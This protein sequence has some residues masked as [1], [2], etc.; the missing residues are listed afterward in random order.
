MPLPWWRGAVFY[1]V[2]VR[3][4]ADSNDD[5]VGDLPGITSR[6]DYIRD[7]GVD[8]IW[9]TP[10]YPSPQKDHGYDVA[11]YYSVNP[12]YGTL[13]DFDRLLARAHDLGLKVLVDIVPNH[14]SNQHEW[15][16]AAVASRDS[17][18]RERYHFADGR[19]DG[20]PPNNW[21]SSFGGPAWS[22]EPS[23]DQWYL[24]LFAPEQPDL[25]WW[26]PEVQ[27]E[28]ERILK[29]WLDR[30]A[31][32]FRLD[33]FNAYF[34]DAQY[35]NNPPALGLRGFDRQRHVYDRDQ[36]EMTGL[37]NDLRRLL[38]TYPERMAVGEV[39]G[40][41]P[42]LA[43]RYCGDGADQL[44]LAFNFEFTRQPWLPRAFQQSILRWEAAL[45]SGAWPCQVLSNHDVD[46][47]VTRFGGGP[48]GDARAKVAAAMLLTLRGTPFLYSGE[49]LGLRNTPIPRAEIQDPP[50]KKYWPFY[51]GRDPERSP[52]PWNGGRGAGFTA[53][54][55][56]LRL[57]PD[58]ARR[59]VD[60]QQTDPDSVFNF[61]RQL[62]SLRRAS[63][64]LR[65]GSYHPLLH[66]PVTALAYLRECP[67]QTMLVALNFFGWEANVEVDESLGGKGWRLR[68]SSASGEHARVRGNTLHLAPFEACVLEA[69]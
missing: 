6:L 69:E 17:P 14:T 52:M 2:Y 20:S 65:R 32:G 8:A 34:K 37:L 41:D 11:D 59:N 10:F 50:G 54:Q 22:R 57:G 53:G 35:R 68:L 44:H 29:F 1:Q 42:A 58:Y 13:E 30:G 31:D 24:H 61:Y 15:F 26:H 7:L 64:A 62:L 27:K 49:E 56:W 36:P 4:F 33:V 3:S 51:G 47:H 5:G 28:F 12:E 39:F 45:H 38:D 19:E 43:A 66:H 48:H 67:E 16:K 46:R 63:P 60:A 9:L 21:T 40:D 18:F 55:P 23:G 25:N